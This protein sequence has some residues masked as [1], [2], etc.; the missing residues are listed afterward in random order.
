MT[1]SRFD[2]EKQSIKSTNIY[3]LSKY[4]AIVWYDYNYGYTNDDV[5]R[6]NSG[7]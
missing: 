6:T 7:G 3:R 5:D 4:S 1:S 2:T